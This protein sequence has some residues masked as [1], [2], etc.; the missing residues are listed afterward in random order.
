MKVDSRYLSLLLATTLHFQSMRD[1]RSWYFKHES[2]S[3]SF[4]FHI[5]PLSSM[6]HE[7]VYKLS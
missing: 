5:L 6:L 4:N 2:S 7:K 3:D 1:V